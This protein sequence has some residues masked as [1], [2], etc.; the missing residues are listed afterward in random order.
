MK[1]MS[2]PRIDWKKTGIRLKNLRDRSQ[3]LRRY[4]CFV[5]HYRD[6]NCT[7]SCTACEF[8]IDANISRAELAVVFQTTENV[9]ANWE[10]G[11]TPPSPEDLLY[12]CKLCDVE[13]EELLVFV[14]AE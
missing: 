3:A 14:S 6:G 9:I 11:K 2:R 12:Y 13:L 4:A 10:S 7:G 5:N 1:L 8:D